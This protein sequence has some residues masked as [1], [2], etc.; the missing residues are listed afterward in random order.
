[1]SSKTCGGCGEV[2]SLEEFALARGR[3]DG[4]QTRCRACNKVYREE[5]RDHIKEVLRD[6]YARTGWEQRLILIYKVEPGW[7]ESKLSSQGGGCA[8]CGTA[9]AEGSRLH[10]D[11]DHGCC[12]FEPKKGTEACGNCVRGLL[13]PGCNVALGHL[14]RSEWRVKAENYIREYG[15][16]DDGDRNA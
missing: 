9:P 3:K 2:K 6:W 8:I 15:V 7:Y 4:R 10:V 1:M 13:C 14:E 16:L 12:P 11:H 5:N